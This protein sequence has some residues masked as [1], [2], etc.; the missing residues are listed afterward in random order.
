MRMNGGRGQLWAVMSGYLLLLRYM[1]MY[2][3]S[4][5]QLIKSNMLV[6]FS[7][8]AENTQSWLQAPTA[9]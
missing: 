4:S 7:I 8:E 2:I 9:S 3:V 6:F 5:F 1:D